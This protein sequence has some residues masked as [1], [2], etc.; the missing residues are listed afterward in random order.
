MN[1]ITIIELQTF[2]TQCCMCGKRTQSRYGI[3]VDSETGEIVANDSERSW[4][5]V[6]A[7]KECHDAHATGAFVG[8]HPKY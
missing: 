7:C 6:P 3:P 8:S 5:G 4:G 2:E 1:T